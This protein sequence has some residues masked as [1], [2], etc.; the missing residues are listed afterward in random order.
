MGL[1]AQT[2]IVFSS[3]LNAMEKMIATM[4]VMRDIVLRTEKEFCRKSKGKNNE[5]YNDVS[6]KYFN[7]HYFHY[8]TAMFQQVVF[9][10]NCKSRHPFS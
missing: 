10:V 4:E 2:K 6:T 8:V 7:L 1:S 3:C 9:H 5:G